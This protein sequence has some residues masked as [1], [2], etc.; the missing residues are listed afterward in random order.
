[1]QL[2]IIAVG[3]KMPTWV[4]SGFDEYA[5]RM[6]SD[7]PIVLK[8]IR[9]EPRVSGKN[10][11]T[12]MRLESQRITAAIPPRSRL[13]ALDERGKDL[14]TEDFTKRLINWRDEAYSCATFLIGGADGLDKILKESAHEVM[15][16]SAFTLPHGLA[17]IVL[18]EQLYRAWSLMNNHPYHRP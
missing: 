17:R 14:N 7:W 11:S 3:N 4:R 2:L 8:E 15:R 5:Q 1:M 18:A 6:S 12:L 16:L 13:I 10:A 9:P